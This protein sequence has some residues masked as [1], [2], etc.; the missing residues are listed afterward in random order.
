MITR[1]CPPPIARD[2][3]ACLARRQR[4]P[5]WLPEAD[6]P[7]TPARRAGRSDP[8]RG[9]RPARDTYRDAR[10]SKVSLPPERCA[11]QLDLTMHSWSTRDE[12][13]PK[14]SAARCTRR[15][16][17]WRPSFGMVKAG[18]V[19]MRVQT[20]LLK[21]ESDFKDREGSH[22]PGGQDAFHPFR[23]S[24]LGCGSRGPGCLAAAAER[25]FGPSS[26]G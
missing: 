14:R 8:T 21:A 20:R 11:P 18:N 1:H 25:G 17:S 2:S 13:K 5:E 24:N 15:S 3:G 16:S 19:P 10:C 4:A 23:S 26:R 12:Q 7:K 22:H 6:S 9:S